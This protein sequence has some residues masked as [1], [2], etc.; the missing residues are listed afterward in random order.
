[1]GLVSFCP[2]K[3]G[4]CMTFLTRYQDVIR[5][6]LAFQLRHWTPPHLK[7]NN[8]EKATELFIQIVLDKAE[9]QQAS[10]DLAEKEPTEDL[11]VE[12]IKT[13]VEN[14]APFFKEACETGF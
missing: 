11:V 2:I 9:K 13:I 10:L 6:F 12:K 1:M 14:K 3:K 4:N 8:I 7:P 5:D